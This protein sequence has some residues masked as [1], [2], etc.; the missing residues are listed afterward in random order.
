MTTPPSPKLPAW[1]VGNEF[2]P[3]HPSASH[4]SPD[5]RDGWNR[6]YQAAQ[7]ALQAQAEE[8]ERLRADAERYR[9]LRDC[10]G[11]L[12]IRAAAARTPGAFDAAI[13]AARAQEKAK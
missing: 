10:P 5:Y 13:D 4:C 9:W 8:V 11:G 12:T 3:Y 6:C 1:K 7:S 2:S